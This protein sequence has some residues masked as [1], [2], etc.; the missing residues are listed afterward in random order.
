MLGLY[1][2]LVDGALQQYIRPTRNDLHH[3][4]VFSHRLLLA[5]L[6]EHLVAHVYRS[7]FLGL[8]NWSQIRHRPDLRG[9][10][11]PPGNSRSLSD[12]VAN[13]DGVWNNAR[14]CLGSDLLQGSRSAGCGRA[15]L[16]IDDGLGNDAGR[17]RVLLCFRMPGISSLVHEPGPAL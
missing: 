4:P 15:E 10:N 2:V 17:D 8:W 16:A 9:R 7:F 5:G 12:A 13:V 11:Y 6:C 3:L 1:R 14:L